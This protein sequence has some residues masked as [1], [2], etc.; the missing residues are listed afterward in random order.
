MAE[1]AAGIAATPPPP[2]DVTRASL[3]T[4]PA[5]VPASRESACTAAATGDRVSSA[6]VLGVV[7]MFELRM[8]ARSRWIL[9]TASGFLVAVLAISYFGLFGA[10]YL[11]FQGFERTA[12][13]LLSLVVYLA[14]LLGLFLGLDRFS[15]SDGTDLL[16]SEP[17]RRVPI[18]LGKL[19]G[20]AL[21]AGA[22]LLVGLGAAGLLIASQAGGDGI[23]GYLVL[24]GVS[25]ALAASFAGIAALAAFALGDRLQASGVAIGAWLWFV[26]LHELVVLGVLF[27]VP[28]ASVRGLLVGSLFGSPVSLARVATLLALDAQPV[29]GAGGAL[30]LRTFGSVGAG[31]VLLAGLALWVVVPWL[32][33]AMLAR[34]REA[35]I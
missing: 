15:A 24:V 9:A 3:D 13:S 22:A 12:T 25:I 2:L 16:F 31:S 35:A 10:G 8:A 19:A 17:G 1:P 7:A 28:E 18:V 26:L 23:E 14:P 34:R 4:S 32:L 6:V 20:L 27:L 11:D 33:A 29:L 30:L 5:R 21:T